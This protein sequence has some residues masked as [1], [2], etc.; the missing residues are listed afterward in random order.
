MDNKKPFFKPHL[1]I[2]I[3]TRNHGLITLQP[4]TPAHKVILEGR[5]SAEALHTEDPKRFPMFGIAESTVRF[6]D[7]ER[8]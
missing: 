4:G 2:H 7:G 3:P 5:S 1:A 8:Y 6:V